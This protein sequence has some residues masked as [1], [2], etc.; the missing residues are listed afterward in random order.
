MATKT[1]NWL[2]MTDVDAIQ[3]Y[4]FSSIRLATIAGAS[5]I[6]ANNDEN[7]VR[8]AKT[9]G[10]K[11]LF[12]AG[13]AAVV[14]LPGETE[15]TVWDFIRQAETEFSQT[16]IAGHLSTSEPIDL[17][18]QGFDKALTAAAESLEARKRLGHP[19]GEIS[20]PP[21][22]Q[23]CEICGN[24]AAI[25][26]HR[27][28]DD[29]YWLGPACDA[30]RKSR[31]RRWLALLRQ[32]PAWS[33]LRF[34]H[35]ADDFS[36]LAGDDYLGV[37]V[38]DVN[39]VGVRLREIRSREDY[40]KFSKGLTLAVKEALKKALLH[41]LSLSALDHNDIFNGIANLP[42][43]VLFLG[44]DDIVVACRGRLALPLVRTLVETFA[45]QASGSWTG[46]SP[47]GMSAGLVLTHPKFPFL[48]AHHI[49]DRL[50][51]EAKQTARKEQWTSGA[52]DFAIV[53]ES[54]ATAETILSDRIIEFGNTSL[55]L[56]GRPLHA[57]STGLRSLG[58]FENACAQ[59]AGRFPRNKLFDLRQFCSASNLKAATNKSEVQEQFQKVQNDVKS[60]L[61]RISRRRETAELW[62]TVLKT[63]ELE[64]NGFYPSGENTWRTPL[65]DLADAI[66]LWGT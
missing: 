64:T 15:K 65:G 6:V 41:A 25:A 19:V 20:T 49:A 13:G 21:I 63:L 58:A 48:S 4:L 18:T 9:L 56:T 40:R 43:Q 8:I 35:L 34:E 52:V 14:L 31:N 39:G 44:G 2:V 7:I 11:A 17:R 28:G 66:G 26:T 57:A 53:S 60:W 38:A 29:L 46:G 16:S 1:M 22:A 24:E 10:G 33:G 50:L 30:K 12:S 47:L 23:R 3:S 42:V 45:E 59:L 51:V 37:I 27:I 32:D 55:F 54:H 62:N 61:M 5:Q 36:K